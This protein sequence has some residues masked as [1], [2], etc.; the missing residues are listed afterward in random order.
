MTS[1]IN[2]IV[3]IGAGQAGS[4]VAAILRSSG[5][6]RAISL[7]GDEPIPPY[8]RPPLSKAFLKDEIGVD[9]LRLRSDSFHSDQKIDFRPGVMAERI[10]R[11]ARMV[12]LA[13]G[14]SE[15]YDI[16]VIA[17]GSRPRL[18]PGMG[19]VPAGVHH[20]RSIEDAQG[21]RSAICPGAEIALV[22]GGYIGLEVAA[23]AV[24][25][26]ATAFVL[27]REER[28]LPRVANAHVSDFLRHY[29]QQRGVAIITDAAV[30]G[31]EQADGRMA[32]INLQDGRRYSCSAVLIGV[33]G[34]PNDELARDAGLRCDGGIVVDR[35]GRTDDPRIFAIGDVSRRP[36]PFNDNRM[37]RLESVSNAIEQSR[38]VAAS[39]LSLARPEDEVP[40]F[41]SDQFD[42]KLKSA[43]LAFDADRR[44][45]R[46]LPGGGNFSVLHL[47]D[48]RLICIETVNNAAD[49]MAGRRLIAS[50][51]AIDVDKAAD[52]A[53]P[54]KNLVPMNNDRIARR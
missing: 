19:D 41:W 50:M 37:H 28:L 11:D 22:G 52:S 9:G 47:K 44:I 21:L 48:E 26:G 17:T 16:L 36:L 45:L 38:Q 31:F 35:D 20:L 29:H 2:R 5:Y 4:S 39:V 8:Q 33:G 53:F 23:A 40:W 49:F 51:A 46:G 27:E 14:T 32:G 30:A 24:H 12:R 34:V 25:L 54:L 10:D 3:I 13:D 1:G 15:P 43:G 42:V 18:L 7:I 6:S